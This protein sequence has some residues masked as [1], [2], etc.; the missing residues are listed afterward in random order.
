[1]VLVYNKTKVIT[2]PI[3]K[4]VEKVRRITDG[5]LDERAEVVLS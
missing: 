3:I 1:M 4:L 5:H 2:A